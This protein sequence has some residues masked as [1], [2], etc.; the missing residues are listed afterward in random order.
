MT[1]YGGMVMIEYLV[2]RIT[3]DYQTADGDDVIYGGDG[4]DTISA[5][6]GRKFNVDG[7]DGDDTLSVILEENQLIKFL[8]P[9]NDILIM[10]R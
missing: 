9:G 7:G 3:Y 5:D 8:G 1:R 4:N 10:L 6:Q 2:V